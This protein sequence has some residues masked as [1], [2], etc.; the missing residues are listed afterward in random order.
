MSKS[1]SLSNSEEQL[2]LQRGT[3]SV[4]LTAYGQS[5]LEPRAHAILEIEG[6]ANAQASIAAL[7]G[8]SK[9][10]HTVEEK[11]KFI[12]CIIPNGMTI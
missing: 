10:R 4:R 8:L 2:V 11:H 3:E 7:L 5:L 6:F 12:R 1:Y 9:L